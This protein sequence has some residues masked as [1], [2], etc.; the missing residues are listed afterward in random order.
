[1]IREEAGDMIRSRLKFA[2]CP[3]CGEIIK[4]YQDFQYVKFR[5]GRTMVY[6]FFHTF[7]LVQTENGEEVAKYG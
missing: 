5:R 4:D 7:C 3:I 1:M 2:V 6:K